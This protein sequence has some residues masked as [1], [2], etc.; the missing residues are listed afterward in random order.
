MESKQ[1][2]PQH[3][4]VH[5]A[6]SLKRVPWILYIN[7]DS[8]RRRDMPNETYFFLFFVFFFFL[9]PPYAR[10][11]PKIQTW[12]ADGLAHYVHSHGQPSTRQRHQQAYTHT[13]TA[14]ATHGNFS[15]IIIITIYRERRIHRRSYYAVWINVDC[16]IMYVLSDT[17]GDRKLCKNHVNPPDDRNVSKTILLFDYHR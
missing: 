6:D 7:A 16:Y 8:R 12:S 5:D 2:P 10:R 11:V 1:V 14:A 9:T 15:I 4:R 17:S 13:H 3:A